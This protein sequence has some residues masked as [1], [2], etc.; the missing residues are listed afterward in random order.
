[1]KLQI[2]KQMKLQTIKTDE[3]TARQTYKQMKIQ[4]DRQIDE[5]TDR[6]T[7]SKADR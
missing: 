2:D 7:Y 5:I 6:Q 4:I 3:I 1:M